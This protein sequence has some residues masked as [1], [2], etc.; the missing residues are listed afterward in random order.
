M[1]MIAGDRRLLAIAI[2]C[3]LLFHAL[4][5]SVRF[6][7]PEALRV[8]PFDP[9]LAVILVN[10]R[11]D[12][13]PLQADALAQANL[14]GGGNADAGSARSPLPD[15]GRIH[16]GTQLERQQQR[17]AELEQ[18][19]RK[20]L[21]QASTQR[22]DP[23]PDG[24]DV[25][26]ASVNGRDVRSVEE[27]QEVA[28]YFSSIT[29]PKYIRVVETAMIPTMRI[30]GEIYFPVGDG[31]QE[32]IGVRIIETPEDVAQT[33][34][35]NPRSGFIAYAPLGSVTRGEALATTGGGGRTTACAV[36]HGPGLKGLGLVP[37][38]AGRSPSYLA[39]QMYDIKLGTRRGAMAALMVPVVANLTDGDMVDIIAYVSSLEP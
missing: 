17:V 11:H 14:D 20:L 2:G 26:R 27:I 35:R 8:A 23:I 13:A 39:R 34:M 25:D 36:C 31:Q 19:Q 3:S 7:S 1:R 30:Q 9:G 33:R 22:A 18:L 38:L 5:L 12:T 6:I 37:N 24:K 21:T 15:L 28:R 29:V 32:P 4:L 16:D 10:A